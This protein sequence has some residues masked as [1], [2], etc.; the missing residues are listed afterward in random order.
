MKKLLFTLAG[1]LLL[2]I[3]PPL[4]ALSVYRLRLLA[5]ILMLFLFV[6]YILEPFWCHFR[7]RGVPRSSRGPRWSLFGP[8]GAPRSSRGLFWCHFGWHFCPFWSH[9]E[10]ILVPFSTQKCIKTHHGANNCDFHEMLWITMLFQWFSGSPRLKM[11]TFSVPRA[12]FSTSENEVDF[13]IDFGPKKSPKWPQ[14]G[15]KMLPK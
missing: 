7:S 9:F 11:V 14:N 8:R 13:Y 6:H 3:S 1:L 5:L 4:L 10:L 12:T 2:T 15:A